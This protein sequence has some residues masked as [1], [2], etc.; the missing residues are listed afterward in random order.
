MERPI[1]DPTLQQ[2][3]VA[4]YDPF[5]LQTQY[6]IIQSQ[7][8]L[9]PVAEQL[10]LMKKWAPG[11]GVELPTE[12]AFR[13]LKG[14]LSVRRFRDT[15]LIE[16][17]VMDEDRFL[18]AE[19]ANRIAKVFESQRLAVKREQT[20]RGIKAMQDEIAQQQ[21]RVKKAQD[22]V[23]R[24]RKELNVP[25]FGTTR[26][27]D[28]TISQL[29]QQLTS[30]RVEAVG[31][32]TRLDE[33]RKL[34]PQQLRNAI[35]TIVT[36]PHVSKLL[37]D[38]TEVDQKLQIL[39]EDFGPDHPA[40]RSAL[41]A[42]EKI[43]EQLND[44]ID[45]VMRGFE[46]DYKMVQQRVDD[47]QKQVDDAK[48]ASMVLESEAYRPFRNAQ[49]EQ[50]LQERLADGLKMRLQQISI[51]LEIPRSPVEVIDQAVPG[52][53]PVKPNFWM[54]MTIGAFFAVILGIGLAFFI[55]F[56]DTSVKK[57][58]DVERHLGIP[59]LGVIAQHAGLLSRDEASPSHVEAYRMLRT[60]IEFATGDGGHKSIAILSGGAGEGK[61]FTCANLATV[62]AQ[63]GMRV[64][65]VDSDLRRP[66][67][68]KNFD[69]KNEIGLAD[70]LAGK[71]TVD[72]I[73]QQ[74]STPNVSI[75]TSGGG[76]AKSALPML[77]SQR[78]RELIKDVG[79]R[80]DLVFYDTPPVLGVSDA[81]VVASE[82]GTAILVIQHRR[83]PRAMAQRS[84]QVIENAGGR[85]LGV[86]VNNVNVSQDETYY[87]YHH[88]Y[89]DYLRVPTRTDKSAPRPGAPTPPPPAGEKIDL[90]EKY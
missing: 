14:R 49:R 75:I 45:G 26:L 63:H 35:A 51:D 44:R 3:Y 66:S 29:E 80:Y 6:E 23:E 15:S 36:D 28:V 13:R 67:V 68:H 65:V 10:N 5:F 76:A 73:I 78:M 64:L 31:R 82:V 25:V 71:Q 84:R 48:S 42:R 87:Y 8:I 43:Q 52:G 47:L 50:E 1:V 57:M 16:I 54:N 90:S 83:F 85:L 79:I 24:L 69:V 70:Y 38:L 58:E 21:E 12:I 46:V 32:K 60:N 22:E 86:V 40:V 88:H 72:A 77:T 74:T 19:I 41:A 9:Y 34:N 33:L 30:A 62:Y 39:K 37:Q 56:L 11:P 4:P 18:A 53:G 20:M 61:S 59:V 27:S 17:T 81:A 89:E 2:Q 55:E 7:N